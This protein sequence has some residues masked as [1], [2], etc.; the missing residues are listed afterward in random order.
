LQNYATRKSEALGYLGRRLVVAREQTLVRARTETARRFERLGA[1]DTRLDQAIRRLIERRS[2]R[3]G[4]FAALL[5]TLSYRAVLARGFALV[6]DE[7]GAP[8][9]AAASVTPG[10][11]LG[12]EFA[13]GTRFARSEAADDTAPG[14]EGPPKRK[15]QP[16]KPAEAPPQQSLFEL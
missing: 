11:R 9:R 16:R 7:D 5:G 10:Q 12:L 15:R 13:D 8:I 3:L 2:D 14:G 6:R 4:N 1:L